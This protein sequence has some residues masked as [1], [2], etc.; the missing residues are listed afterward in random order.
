MDNTQIRAAA[1]TI[2]MGVNDALRKTMPD[3]V[4]EG[5]GESASVELREGAIVKIEHIIKFYD[6]PARHCSECSGR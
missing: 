3:E 4:K 2:W 6:A 5:F 1:E